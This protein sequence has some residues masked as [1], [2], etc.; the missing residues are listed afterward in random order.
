MFRCAYLLAYALSMLGCAD[1]SSSI[2]TLTESEKSMFLSSVEQKAISDGA[3]YDFDKL[4]PVFALTGST[5]T[6]SYDQT[7]ANTLGGAPVASIDRTTGAIID[8]AY[9]R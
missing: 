9:T 4:R 8:I 2:N 6:L 3:V 1:N 7:I 5:V